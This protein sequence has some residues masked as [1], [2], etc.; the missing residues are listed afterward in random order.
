MKYRSINHAHRLTGL[1]LCALA[2]AFMQ[3]GTARASDPEANFQSARVIHNVIVNGQKGMRVHATFSVRYGKGVPCKLIAYFFFDD[4][5]A[6]RSADPRYST[7]DGS[8]SSSVRFR[9]AYD[10]ANYKEL[11]IF[12]PYSALNMEPGDD[13]DLKF[14]LSMYD[15][16]TQ[17]FFGKSGWY[18]FQLTVP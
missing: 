9:P 13:Y 17:R 10:P 1:L 4:G 18:R 15:E 11:A 16:S 7:Q 14:Y 5:T 12:I 2:I 6:L 8:V 3:A